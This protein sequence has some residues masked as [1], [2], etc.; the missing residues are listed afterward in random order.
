MVDACLTGTIEKAEMKKDPF[1]KVLVPTSC[2]GIT[3]SS[4]LD[5]G[6]T[7]ENRAEYEARAKKLA[8]EFA[9]HF[10]KAYGNQNIS[11]EIAAE[12]PGM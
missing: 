2:P 10:R 12:C 7:W 5:P 8:G 3:D 4:M 11:E 1:F 6:N 9:A